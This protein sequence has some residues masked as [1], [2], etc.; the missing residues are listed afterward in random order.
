MDSEIEA[1]DNHEKKQRGLLEEQNKSNVPENVLSNLF[2]EE[3]NSEEI[4][5]V[6]SLINQTVTN[7]D[8][9]NNTIPNDKDT[10]SQHNPVEIG[11]RLA[12][13]Q[14]SDSIFENCSTYSLTSPEVLPNTKNSSSQK[15]HLANS[16]K[17]LN[18]K[19]SK[20]D[21]D[22]LYPDLTTCA[23]DKKSENVDND[24]YSDDHMSLTDSFFAN[25][26]NSDDNTC[27]NSVF[28]KDADSSLVNKRSSIFS[29]SKE[30]IFSVPDESKF[31]SEASQLKSERKLSKKERKRQ[32]KNKSNK[33]APTYDCPKCG[34]S[35]VLSNNASRTTA[36]CLH[37][38]FWKSVEPVFLKREKQPWNTCRI[39]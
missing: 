1:A 7:E 8:V 30:S 17:F 12:Q 4:V 38:D 34:V 5:Q 26:N 22:M 9:I 19:S 31:D 2:T 37:C 35:Y 21:A 16:S 23:D 39:C 36:R 15:T 14:F 28:S 24:N 6:Q 20:S 11:L 10:S 29:L 32:K 13:R 18:N 33:D 27:Q 3:C 25:V